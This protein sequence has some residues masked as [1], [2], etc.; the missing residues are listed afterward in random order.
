MTEE[1][2]PKF[3]NKIGL[4][5]SCDDNYVKILAVALKSIVENSSSNNEY[6]II[7]MHTD[8]SESSFEILKQVCNKVNFSIRL[9][10]VSEFLKNYDNNLFYLSFYYNIST[11]YRLFITD[12]FRNFERVIYFDADMIF[13][14]DVAKLYD[15][16]FDDNYLI[17]SNDLYMHILI[18]Y[19]LDDWEE[20]LKNT[21]RMNNPYNYV[22]AG[23]LIF[24]IKKCIENNLSKKLIE[25]LQEIGKPRIVDQDV[26]NS[27]L[28]NK[29][30]NMPNEWNLDLNIFDLI[31]R[32]GAN[33]VSKT[34]KEKFY[35]AYKNVKIIH[36]A[37]QIKPWEHL[38]MPKSYE[39]WKYAIKTPALKEVVLEI[40]SKRTRKLELLFKIYW[41]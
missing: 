34:A 8:I 35:E 5:F 25:R 36:Y 33:K 23:V 40:F 11:Y 28:E 26:I 10:D 37:G 2:R 15:I 13:T 21:L 14:D 1:F 7:V 39:F 3:Q 19:K 41:A 17:A 18:H 29:I 27:L 9:Y 24:N 32:F 30:K 6:D 31:K 38:F 4:C 16:D 12:I 22:Q 20:Y